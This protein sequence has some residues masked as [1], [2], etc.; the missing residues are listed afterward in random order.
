MRPKLLVH[1]KGSGH[2]T[3]IPT[4][5]K[6]AVELAVKEGMNVEGVESLPEIKRRLLLPRHDPKNASGALSAATSGDLV[7]I[8]RGIEPI[9]LINPETGKQ[10]RLLSPLAAVLPTV[11]KGKHFILNDAG[12]HAEIGWFQVAI[13]AL[14][15]G[16]Y[17]R[18]AYNSLYPIYGIHS[19]GGETHKLHP[20]AAKIY[21]F[22]KGNGRG[23]TVRIAE[24]EVAFSGGIQ[25]LVVR[26]GEIGN[27]L[28][29]TAETSI[30]ALNNVI[31]QEVTSEL[32]SKLMV[33]M[34][35]NAFHRVKERIYHDDVHGALLLGSGQLLMKQH[36]RVEADELLHALK[37]LERYALKD[38]L[39]RMRQNFFQELA[40]LHPEVLPPP[41][42]RVAV[43]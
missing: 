2:D 36:G 3:H 39:A 1:T 10:E 28:L 24:P 31:K 22:L 23:R 19:I 7:A 16:S 43:G 5:A 8:A 18:A 30:R 40:R 11:E 15:C 25:V 27:T 37:R 20:E 13:G 12:A 34:A 6:A 41:P 38:T 33:G 26:N 32:W 17:H 42:E 21:D 14:L 29:K 35:Q 4:T 9:W